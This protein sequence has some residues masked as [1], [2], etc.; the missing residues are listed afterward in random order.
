MNNCDH[1]DEFAQRSLSRVTTPLMLILVAFVAACGGG[2]GEDKNSGSLTSSALKVSTAAEMA[3][4][5]ASDYNT[6]TYGLI[7]GA[8]LK[9]WKNDWVNQRP[10]GITGKLVILQVTVGEAGYEYIKTNGTNAF[11]YLAA[12]AEWTMTRSNGMISTTTMVLDG[13]SMDA[14]LKKYDIDPQNDMIVIATGTGTASNVMGQ[15]RAWYALRYWGVDAKNIAIL[16]GGNKWQNDVSLGAGAMVAAT[17][18]SLTGA[19]PPLTGLKSVKSLAIDNTVMQA[20]VGDVMA[21]VPAT[22]SNV[23]SDGIFLW[24]ARTI[25]QYSAGL[26][27]EKQDGT[28]TSV[29]ATGAYCDAAATYDYMLSFQNG[30]TRQGH[31]NG[32]IDLNYLNLVDAAKGGSF[33]SKAELAAY[34]NG[35]ADAS[36]YGMVDGSYNLAGAG[37]AYQAGDTVI[38]YCETSQRAMVTGMASA[39][40]L[41]H[42]TRIYDG[43]M[44]EWNSLSYMKDLLGNYILPE[45]SPWRTDLKSFYRAA[46]SFTLVQLRKIIDPFAVN[47]NGIIAEDKA[48]KTPAASSTSRS[49]GGAAPANPCGG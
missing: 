6:N 33:K 2:G 19:T 12:S 22:D 40:I 30:G 49:G 47:A 9:R 13:P 3:V 26:K 27:R 8:T 7:T 11:T 31:P 24:D 42:P 45:N 16:N 21:V 5:S 4:E 20:T 39:V 35:E 25:T 10:A 48:Y 23:K 1:I 32:A 41:G 17:D 14:Q 37:N 43:A 15:G 46:S 18:Y 36:G 34:M 29:C 38:T 28:G 44:I